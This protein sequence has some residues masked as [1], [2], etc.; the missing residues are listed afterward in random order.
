MKTTKVEE[1]V[2][3]SEDNVYE[4]LEVDG[5]YFVNESQDNAYVTVATADTKAEADKALTAY[6]K[7][8]G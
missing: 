6:V 7:D 5:K 8:E 4:I 1:G 2:Y 3:R